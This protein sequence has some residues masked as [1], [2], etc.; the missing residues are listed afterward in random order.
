M[1]SRLTASNDRTFVT[2]LQEYDVVRVIELLRANRPFDGS[3]GIRRPT[4]VGDV[5]TICHEYD[6]GDPAAMVA[7]EMVDDDGSTIWL[8][9]FE[10]GELELLRR[11]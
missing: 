9:D 10:R 7:V 1:M 3:D 6:P 5:A 11:P 2:R 8:A 4:R